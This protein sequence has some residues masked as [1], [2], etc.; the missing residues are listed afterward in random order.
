MLAVFCSVEAYNNA[1]SQAVKSSKNSSLSAL[2]VKFA[3]IL[4]RKNDG[5]RENLQGRGRVF[6]GSFFA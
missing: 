5:F 1:K 4:Q 6:A 3:Q 2:R